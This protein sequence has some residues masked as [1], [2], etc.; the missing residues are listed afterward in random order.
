[1]LTNIHALKAAV[2]VKSL[3]LIGRAGVERAASNHHHGYKTLYTDYKVFAGFLLF[4]RL[5][6][7]D[8]SRLAFELFRA[9]LFPG[10]WSL[11]SP[12]QNTRQEFDCENGGSRCQ[13]TFY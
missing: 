1:M 11:Y 12:R 10:L 5:G 4:P 8:K 2:F 7:G 13:S 3:L 6:Q 9:G